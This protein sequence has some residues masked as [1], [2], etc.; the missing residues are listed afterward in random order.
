MDIIKLLPKNVANQIAAG[1]VIQRPASAVKEMLENAIDSGAK[2]IDLII[3]DAGKTMIKV[4]DD[5]CGMSK[6]DAPLSFKRHA[7]SKLKS[8]E[9]LFCIKTMGFRGEAMSSMAAI[10]HIELKTKL[11]SEKIG[12]KIIIEGGIVTKNEDFAMNS[13]TSIS[14]KNLFYNVPARRNFLKSDKIELKHIL[15]E[16]QR[17]SISNP[18]V[19]IK[20][21]HD[22]NEVF[23]LPV[24]NLKS[25]I[26]NTFSNSYNEKLVPVK[27]STQLITID[28]FIVKPEFCKKTKGEQYF[29][30]NKRYIKSGYLYHAV[31]S[32]FEGLIP[33]GYNPSYFL[34]F[35][36]DPKLIDI[37]IHPTKTEIKFEDEQAIYAILKSSIKHSLG[38]HNITPT[39]DF[40]TDP[41]FNQSHKKNKIIKEPKI[42]FDSSYNPFNTE[43][44]KKTQE[45][46]NSIFENLQ[47]Q[48]NE[49]QQLEIEDSW[50]ESLLRKT[51]FQ[52]HNQY[53][54]SPIKSGFIIV[55][56]KRAHERILYEK[57]LLKSNEKE[58]IQQL[59]F[60]QTIELNITDMSLIHE[61]KDEIQELG[62]LWEVMGKNKIVIQGIPQNAI[63][64]D[65][66]VIFEEF[67][68]EYK[69][70]FK[71]PTTNKDKLAR[72]LA[73]S[74]T[75]QK[76]QKL[77]P[78]EMNNLID[79]LFAC[80]T[81]NISPNGKA[82]L[83]TITFEEL[84][85][86]FS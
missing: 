29:F 7:T 2:N 3:E 80:E 65:T 20:M 84:K 78:I 23:N 83:I 56:Q 54:L 86:K 72:A 66:Q 60:P 5:G 75:I 34:F 40:E 4:V 26:I 1:E 58:N 47:S 53:I 70:H 71:I 46:L 31:L 44:N 42:K 67:L 57:F 73:K 77:S 45:N 37:N 18:D 82:T 68:E 62:F 49:S 55:N 35:E 50:E 81:P 61:I 64:E 59:L 51:C 74:M 10:A 9:D 13:G 22:K 12:R 63:E 41:L 27:E 43:K 17:I 38:R 79:N 25:R 24:S 76:T 19:N 6:K 39:L 11:H 48:E 28:G 16:F 33:K 8:A 32:A 69:N 52:I 85:D 21:Y 14:I 30:V 36:I 15:E